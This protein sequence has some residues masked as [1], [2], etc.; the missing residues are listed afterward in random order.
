MLEYD[1]CNGVRHLWVT[2]VHG[3]I[4]YHIVWLGYLGQGSQAADR[5]LLE[6]ILASF[7]FPTAAGSTTGPS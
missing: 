2:A 5:A 1:Q 3:T 6:S 7:Q 4:G